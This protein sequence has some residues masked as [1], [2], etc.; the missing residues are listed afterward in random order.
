[1]THWQRAGVALGCILASIGI[2]A[3][4]DRDGDKAAGRRLAERW[5]AECHQI[6]AS[7]S[8]VFAGPGFPDI[9]QLPSTTA[10]SLKVFLRSSHQEMPNFQLTSEDTE[11][12]VA[13]ILSLKGR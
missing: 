11:D 5:C 3:A 4:Q 9:A 6:A 8:G 10:L 2:S 12:V 13:Y 7:R 1:M